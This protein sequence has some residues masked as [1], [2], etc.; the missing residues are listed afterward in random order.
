M[1]LWGKAG[2]SA[3]PWH[4]LQNGK[5][6]PRVWHPYTTSI[7]FEKSFNPNSQLQVVQ[8]NLAH[9]PR[10]KMLQTEA[11][12][13]R[14][15]KGQYIDEPIQF[16]PLVTKASIKGTMRQAF[17]LEFDPNTVPVNYMTDIYDLPSLLGQPVNNDAIEAHVKQI[18]KMRANLYMNQQLASKDWM[19]SLRKGLQGGDARNLPPQDDQLMRG[20]A[21]MIGELKEEF[22]HDRQE[23]QIARI[24]EHE[25]TVRHLEEQRLMRIIAEQEHVV[26]QLRD[27][28]QAMEH[29]VLLNRSVIAS[30][31]DTIRSLVFIQEN[32]QQQ[33][34]Q[35]QLTLVDRGVQGR[36]EEQKSPAQ[37]QWDNF[38]NA[39][40]PRLLEQGRQAP[41]QI[42]N[43]P[44][45]N[46]I[47]DA[48]LYDMYAR[49]HDRDNVQR[50]ER[51]QHHP[52]QDEKKDDDLM[53]EDPKVEPKEE[54]KYEPKD[55][56]MEE[57]QPIA[58]FVQ[59]KRPRSQALIE[60]KDDLDEDKE[61][62]FQNRRNGMPALERSRSVPY[63]PPMDERN[64]VEEENMLRGDIRA[65]QL[66]FK[67]FFIPD[68]GRNFEL[69]G[70]DNLENL[71]VN[72]YLKL[73]LNRWLT[74]LEGHLGAKIPPQLML[75][76]HRNEVGEA[77]LVM[78]SMGRMRVFLAE[79]LG[80]GSS[81]PV[82]ARLMDKLNLCIRKD[83]LE[84]FRE[85]VPGDMTRLE[86]AL[87]FAI[88][89]I[90]FIPDPDELGSQ[91]LKEYQQ[92]LGQAH[93]L[94][95]VLA[96]PAFDRTVLQRLVEHRG[97]NAVAA[98]AATNDA[99]GNK[100]ENIIADAGD[101][102]EGMLH[103]PGLLGLQMAA[104]DAAMELDNA[105]P[106]NIHI[107]QAA[108]A[109]ADIL[110][111]VPAVA[112]VEMKEA[113]RDLHISVD[114]LL[115][116]RR[117]LPEMPI[118]EN[119]TSWISI[120]LD[121]V[122]QQIREQN[123]ADYRK[124]VGIFNN[125]RNQYAP[126]GAAYERMSDED[127]QFLAGPA[128][129]NYRAFLEETTACI[130]KFNRS[131]AEDFHNAMFAGLLVNWEPTVAR[132]MPWYFNAVDALRNEDIRGLSQHGGHS[133]AMAEYGMDLD[134]RLR[135]ND[136]KEMEQKES[137]V[138]TW[139]LTDRDWHERA[140]I[141]WGAG[142]WYRVL[143]YVIT[144]VH[145]MHAMYMPAI[146]WNACPTPNQLTTYV[147]WGILKIRQ[148]EGEY[149]HLLLDELPPCV[150]VFEENIDYFNGVI[151]PWLIF[152]TE[153]SRSDIV[154]DFNPWSMR[155]LWGLAPRAQIQ[156]FLATTNNSKFYNAINYDVVVGTLN[157]SP[158][159]LDL[160][161]DEFTIG[162][163]MNPRFLVD[164]GPKLLESSL[165]FMKTLINAP[166][167]LKKSDFDFFMA[168]ANPHYQTS[169]WIHDAAIKHYCHAR[170]ERI[171][172]FMRYD[173]PDSDLVWNY[174]LH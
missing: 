93:I 69:V 155:Y 75:Q 98:L 148:Q 100:V 68:F 53:H 81:D 158:A 108:F 41:L 67:R 111:E 8:S 37:E 40:V 113:L 164:N 4:T 91:Y 9:A 24:T 116:R 6:L 56:P 64:A 26:R 46:F 61:A 97:R 65:K 3:S 106:D 144:D 109:E 57:E 5:P 42:A 157:N 117:Q 156:N 23:P 124:Y 60:R 31:Q 150:R 142:Y 83:S 2:A 72:A 77:T 20:M 45:D 95:G 118:N 18:N 62:V 30:N 169:A 87:H 54:P 96:D 32:A 122:R 119:R 55:D 29:E 47:D 59:N 27:A 28:Q 49:N 50:E 21:Q 36:Q 79:A 133:K 154:E 138:Q 43:P 145:T 19:E 16:E 173:T 35:P 63:I 86:R 160:I 82:V 84:A 131:L 12:E 125:L 161:L 159:A 25:R 34:Q 11:S 114:Q 141:D 14:I 149:A 13:L 123:P 76:F 115:E 85:P 120:T 162:M 103:D 78:D 168:M 130:A 134:E 58:P 143:E 107:E 132:L 99:F 10:A 71:A 147:E 174:A 152:S 73:A 104:H 153:V 127:I 170:E 7:S 38:L 39:E 74:L 121:H 129:E 128:L 80:I 22:Q 70:D 89:H 90:F 48:A 94:H 44:R 126:I 140:T 172:Q 136:E 52:L 135:P 165:L 15:P 92:S 171:A 101:D 66:D 33:Q 112:P 51:R 139:N 151:G 137:L 88:L 146:T 105:R 110:N 166:Q 102:K 1:S 163:R 167:Y 17:D